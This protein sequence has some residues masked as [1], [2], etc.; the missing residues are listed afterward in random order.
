[1]LGPERALVDGVVTD[2]EGLAF[3]EGARA[4]GDDEKV[5]FVHITSIGCLKQNISMN[6]LG[7][8]RGTTIATSGERNV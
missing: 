3:G 5:E 8:F 6:E 2:G 7:I 4:G 1:M